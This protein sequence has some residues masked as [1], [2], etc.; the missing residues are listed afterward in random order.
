MSDYKAFGRNVKAVG[1]SGEV[2]AIIATFDVIDKDRDVTRKGFFGTQPT[3]I[4][5]AHDWTAPIGKG[6]ITETDV[7]ARFNG[8]FFLN[9]TR[10]KDAWETVKAM[11]DMQEWSYGFDILDGG[12]E[13]GQLDGQD[14]RF[15]QASASGSAGAK[16][17]EVS[18]V[19][20]GAGE[21]TGTVELR[22]FDPD[23][24]AGMPFVD[25]IDQAAR[26][27]AACYKRAVE[28]ADLRAESGKTLGVESRR[29]LIDLNLALADLKG[30]VDALLTVEDDRSKHIRAEFVRYQALARRITLT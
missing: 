3:A 6:S 4:V 19:L 20:V 9:T 15:L 23:K 2:E 22:A 28:I 10:G 30:S 8:K 18:P 21:G 11:G 25:E 7:D 5:W 1:D 16:V 29:R 17:Y 26:E 24:T 12:S 14:V 13:K 27:V